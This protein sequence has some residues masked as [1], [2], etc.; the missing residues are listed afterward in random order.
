MNKSE[1]VARV[2]AAFPHLLHRD[3]EQIIDMI[4]DEIV[5]ALARGDKVELRDFGVFA[6]KERAARTGH[7]PRTGAA[8]AIEAKRVPVFRTGKKLRNEVNGQRTKS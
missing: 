7:N 2:A 3:V 8:I 1:L 4:F 5:A 6:V